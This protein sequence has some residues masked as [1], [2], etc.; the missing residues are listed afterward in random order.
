MMVYA[1]LLIRRNMQAAHGSRRRADGRE[2]EFPGIQVEARQA[3]D[4]IVHDRVGEVE[5]GDALPRLAERLLHA[6]QAEILHGLAFRQLQ[7]DLLHHAEIGRIQHRDLL[8]EL[9]QVFAVGR[10]FEAAAAPSAAAAVRR[11]LR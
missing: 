8:A 7:I 1:H 9:V 11:R 5:Q 10:D 2:I 6:A 4:A 3:E